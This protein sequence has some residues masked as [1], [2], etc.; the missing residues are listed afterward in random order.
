MT[1]GDERAFLELVERMEPGS[2]LRRARYLEGGVSAHIAAIEITRPTGETVKLIVRRH[3]EID[4]AANPHIARDEYRLLT[5][6]RHHGV[7]APQPIFLDESCGLF[8]TPLLVIEFVEGDSGS[9]P[10]HP[11]EY[12]TRMTAEL[13]KIHAIPDSPML[14]FLPRQGRGSGEPPEVLD[15][16]M[17]E[18]RIREALESAWP[19]E[20]VNPDVLL[21]GDYWPGNLLWNAEQLVAVIDWE[22]ARVG[23][24]LSDLGNTRMEILFD[25]GEQVMDAFTAHYR[26]LTGIDLGNLAYWDLSAALRPCGRLAGWGLDPDVEARMRARHAWFVQQ[27]LDCIN[28]A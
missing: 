12:V 5:I 3:G 19:V 24:P 26:S 7:A 10:L 16:S 21:H 18:G 6:V 9:F 15:D 17:H 4:L 13:A 28:R 1:T 8:P 20:Q 14:S 23:D 11:V 25:K 22:D 27:V 2:V